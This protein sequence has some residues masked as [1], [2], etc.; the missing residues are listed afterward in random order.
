MPGLAGAIFRRGGRHGSLRTRPQQKKNHT[1]FRPGY[2][3]I[4]LFNMIAVETGP[5]IPGRGV[6]VQSSVLARFLD[7]QGEKLV[8]FIHTLQIDGRNA[9]LEEIGDA[10]LSE[11]LV[12]L[13]IDLKPKQIL[14][15]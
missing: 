11:Q 5:R 15:E 10:V 8:P 3:T 12:F 2:I 4:K 6:P 13:R 7:R 9:G 1:D 14:Q